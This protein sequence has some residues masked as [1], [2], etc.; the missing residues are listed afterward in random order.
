MREELKQTG[1]MRNH[2]RKPEYGSI[3]FSPHYMQLYQH[4][5][6]EQP[7]GSAVAHPPTPPATNSQ[8]HTTSRATLKDISP[9]HTPLGGSAGSDWTPPPY[10][11]PSLSHKFPESWM[12]I[13]DHSDVKG[14]SDGGNI[15]PRYA[16]PVLFIFWVKVIDYPPDPLII[17]IDYNSTIH[18]LLRLSL[19]RRKTNISPYPISRLNLAPTA[20]RPPMN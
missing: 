17:L 19:F 20:S 5:Y 15:K 12:S 4:F 1:A 6:P 7:D 10:I 13:S 3:R 18:A 2:P 8:S 16:P 14:K 9:S 11:V